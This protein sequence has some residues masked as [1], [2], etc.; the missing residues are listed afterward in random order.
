MLRK[1][2]HRC[3]SSTTAV[4]ALKSKSGA[5]WAV[6][7]Q[8]ADLDKEVWIQPTK[9][10]DVTASDTG[11]D[12]AVDGQLGEFEGCSASRLASRTNPR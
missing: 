3:E 9:M 4:Q 2:A 10:P 12:D 7:D 8:L 1:H 5:S 11:G 6:A